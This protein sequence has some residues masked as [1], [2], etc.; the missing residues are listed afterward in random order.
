[1]VGTASTS[2][3]FGVEGSDQV[4]F[5]FL[6]LTATTTT[7]TAGNGI[8][9]SGTTSDT[10]LNLVYCY[11]F[12]DSLAT[13]TDAHYSASTAITTDKMWFPIASN[14]A[15]LT[16]GITSTSTLDVPITNVNSKFMKI[17]FSS[18]LST[19][20]RMGLWAEAILKKGY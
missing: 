2:Y 20:T 11:H 9:E 17:E 7:L 1:M 8:P 6:Y 12:T 3:A 18:P 16:P 4:S 19:S 14:C 10:A 15:T 5:N 13:T